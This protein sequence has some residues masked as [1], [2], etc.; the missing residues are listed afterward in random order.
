MSDHRSRQAVEV[1]EK[2][3]DKQATEDERERIQAIAAE[4]RGLSG[5]AAKWTAAASARTGAIMTVDAAG[6]TAACPPGQ[7]YEPAKWEAEWQEQCALLRDIFGNPFSRP[8]ALDS[9]CLTSTVV[10]IAQAIYDDRSFDDLPI[11]ADALEE[12]GCDNAEFLA[13]CRGSGPH[14]RGCWA[15]DLVLRKE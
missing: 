13:H 15:L 1:A 9:T 12:A 7:E 10:K 11:L 8:V 14:V 4:I 6:Q 5:V 2:V 3:A